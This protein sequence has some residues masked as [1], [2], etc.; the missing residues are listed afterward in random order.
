[1]KIKHQAGTSG[2]KLKTHETKDIADDSHRPVFSFHYLNKD[3]C[4]SK[5]EKPEKVG[6]A[7]ALRK[8]SQFPWSE[9]KGVQAHG[10]GYERI[11]RKDMRVAIPS[12]ITNDIDI[13]AFR[14]SGK[15]PMVGYR[16]AR[17]RKLFHVVWLDRKFKV[18]NHGS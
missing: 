18:Y 17:D 15:K 2:P 14:F 7:D 13:I 11:D 6:L 16:D 3:Y 1:M 5:C 10:L 8:L 12:Q 4:I 9:L